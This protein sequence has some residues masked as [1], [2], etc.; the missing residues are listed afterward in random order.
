MKFIANLSVK[1]AVATTLLGVSFFAL[2][3]G[4]QQVHLN[5]VMEQAC[6]DKDE[7]DICD[8]TNDRGDSVNGQCKR[9][10]SPDGKLNCVPNN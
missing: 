1:I 6:M 4:Q 8:F 3:G 7:G 9:N 2:A 5:Q 10:G